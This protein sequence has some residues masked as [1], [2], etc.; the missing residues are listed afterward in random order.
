MGPQRGSGGPDSIEN[1]GFHWSVI[2]K[3]PETIHMFKNKEESTTGSL[4]GAVY[5]HP[6]GNKETHTHST[7]K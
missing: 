3:R 1:A 4:V 7:E 6:T 5:T 2:Y